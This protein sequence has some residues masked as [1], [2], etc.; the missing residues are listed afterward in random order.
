MSSVTIKDI[1]KLAGVSYATVSRALNGAPGISAEVR[2][3]VLELCR[4]HGYRRNLLARSLSASRAGLIG[5]ILPSLD[6]PLFAEMSLNVEQYARHCGYH[7]ML[8]HGV[9]E[10]ANISELFDFLIGHRVDGI[11]LFS[12]SRQAPELVRRYIGR[13]P[14]VLQGIF[15]DASP[16][17]PIPA[18]SVD[19]IA[20]GRLAAEYL[21]SL[22]HRR[23]V[24]LGMRRHNVAHALRCQGFTEAARYLE[25]SVQILPNDELSSTVDIGY[26][27]AKQFFFENFTQTAMFA[28]CDSIAL[29][30]MAAASEFE[31]SIPGQL[32]LLGFDNISYS[33]LPNICLST[34]DPC[35]KQLLEAT[36]DR[37]LELIDSPEQPDLRPR[38]IR[39]VLCER[40]TCRRV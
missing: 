17:Q 21:Y 27:L 22:G 25:M 28:A 35:K 33:A 23:V 19:N 5:C 40:A 32:S 2:A 31:L 10:D 24:Y 15:D 4:Q 14:V 36:V 9:A 11:L 38:L 7:V 18:V 16:E 3:R 6:N 34:I 20:G 8:C 12:S 1:A 39:P 13:V 26:R 29:G 30:V 37:L